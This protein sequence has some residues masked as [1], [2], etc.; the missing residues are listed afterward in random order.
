VRD[1]LEGRVAPTG[2]VVVIDEI[3]FHHATSVAELLADR[4]CA[5]EVITPGMVVGQDLGITLD[6]ENWWIRAGAKGIVQS[7]ELVPM[8]MEGGTLSLQHHPTGAMVERRPDWVV[9]AVPGTPADGLYHELRAA[10]LEVHRVGDCVAP[11]RAH[12]A[13]IE[14]ERA[15]ASV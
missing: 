9:C 5:V 7:T 8:G 3:G 6:M 10:G 13:V 4:D 11:R 14:G 1:V 15:G 12:A 2:A